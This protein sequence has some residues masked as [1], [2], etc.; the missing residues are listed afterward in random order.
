MFFKYTLFPQIVFYS[1]FIAVCFSYSCKPEQKTGIQALPPDESAKD[2]GSILA[3]SLDGKVLTTWADPD[4]VNQILTKELDQFRNYYLS[5]LEEPVSYLAYG[6]KFL[7]LGKIENA[8]DIFS[9]GIAKFDKNPDLY[10]ARG[11]AH[12]KARMFNSA[13]DDLWKGGQNIQGQDIGSGLLKNRGEDSI[14]NSSLSYKN[15]LFLGQA[16]QCKGDFANAD[17][18]FEIC[19]DFSTN[20]DLYMRSYY[21][22]YQCFARSG[23][24]KEAEELI[25]GI[26]P[27]SHIFPVT[28]PYLESLLFLRGDLSEAQLVDI[29]KMPKTSEEAKSW[30]VRAYAVALKAQL[31]KDQDKTV[32]VFKN[33]FQSGYWDQMPYIMAEADYARLLGIDI[34]ESQTIQLRAEHLKNKPK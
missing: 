19:A 22:Q 11:E 33:I 14:I 24:T 8:I 28:K 18:M 6:R 17:K 20:S 15:Y 10:I 2:P 25:K 1:L 3:V 23:R 12:I 21:W 34:Q 32:S 29:S 16:F 13:T 26:D 4:S 31:K 7:Q 9:K 27:K 5:H 30:L